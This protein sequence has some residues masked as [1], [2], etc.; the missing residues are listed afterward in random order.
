M[1]ASCSLAVAVLA[2]LAL[3][4]AGNEAPADK[5]ARLRVENALLRQAIEEADQKIKQTEATSAAVERYLAGATPRASPPSAGT[6]KPGNSSHET[7]GGEPSAPAPSAAPKEI[8]GN[9]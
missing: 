3:S 8:Q 1:S 4:A 2:S 9:S 5:I 7:S 6:Y